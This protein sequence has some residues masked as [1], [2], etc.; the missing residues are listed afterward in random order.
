MGSGGGASACVRPYRNHYL[1][2]EIT[3][4]AR[5]SATCIERMLEGLGRTAVAVTDAR[6]ATG[7]CA[8]QWEEFRT[9]DEGPTERKRPAASI[10]WLSCYC[11][12][13]LGE[14]GSGAALEVSWM[15]SEGQRTAE[16]HGERDVDADGR[17]RARSP[18]CPPAARRCTAVAKLCP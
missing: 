14:A 6:S 4:G 3:G 11:G 7:S 9:G 13:V 12:G 5:R 15:H 2:L 18:D 16:F 1:S 17:P 10:V 8:R